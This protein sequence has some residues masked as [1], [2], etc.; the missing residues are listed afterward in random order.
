MNDTI[1]IDQ[2]KADREKLKLDLMTCQAQL[3]QPA[4]TLLIKE[5]DSIQQRIYEEGE[6]ESV[7]F[8]DAVFWG[9][10]FNRED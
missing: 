8:I 7:S 3:S 4:R 1:T 6:P 2:M 10:D 5:I 9:E